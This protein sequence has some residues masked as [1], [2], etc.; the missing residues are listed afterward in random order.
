MSWETYR[1]G[2]ILTLKRGHDLPSSIRQDGDVPVVSSSG[3]TGWHNEYKSIAPGIVTGRYGTLGEVFFI[4]ENYWPLNTALY[5]TDFKGSNPRFLYYLLKYLLRNQQSDKAA[6]PGVNRNVLHELKVKFTSNLVVQEL[7]AEILNAYDDLIENNTRQIK[8]LEEAARQLYKE[9]FVRLRF[10]GHE[11]FRVVDGV[12]EGWRRKT[13][14]ELA[15]INMGQSPVSK[16][17]NEVGEGLPFHQG[18]SDFGDR[19][20]SHRIYSTAYNRI[21]EPGDILCSVRAPVGRLNISIDKIVIGRG[22]AAVRSQT[23]NQ[24][25]LFYQLRTHFFKEDLIGAGAIFASVT[26]KDF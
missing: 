26:K 1:L 16:F 18:V 24:S 2:D 13:L 22:L 5:V 9:W 17:Y 21:A 3:I 10:P 15:C 25:F 19:F 7:T 12:P 20:V 4:N 14:G 8:I 11:H 6:V 23:D